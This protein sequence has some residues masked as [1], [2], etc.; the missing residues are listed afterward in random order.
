MSLEREIKESLGRHADDARP[1]PAGLS[2]IER[3]VARAHRRR[4]GLVTGAGVIVLAAIGLALPR[5]L[6][7]N[8]PGLYNPGDDPSVDA[9]ATATP[10]E[11]KVFRNERDA[12]QLSMPKDW[13]VTRFEGTVEL[14]P[15]GQVGRNARGG[16]RAGAE[17]DGF[18]VELQQ[19]V[20]QPYDEPDP[21]Y[22]EAGYDYAPT[23][24]VGGRNA[25][26]A[27]RVEK[28]GSR[29]V[30]V[31]IDWTGA[32]CGKDVLCDAE[33]ATLRISMLATS[34]ELWD[35]FEADGQIALE[36]LST[37]QD[38]PEPAGTV[39]TLYGT[40]DDG[41]PYDDVT[42]FVVRFMDARIEGAGA[43]S[44]LTTET[45]QQY[46]QYEAG[47]PKGVGL[48]SYQCPHCDPPV[49][50]TPWLTY[51]IVRRDA[52][53]ANPFEYKVELVAPI[54]PDPDHVYTSELIGVGR[55]GAGYE[56]RSVRSAGSGSEE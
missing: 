14:L 36:M 31:R 21:D 41:V 19:F 15:P 9:T 52:V 54:G 32:G 3:K 45:S 4:L 29:E 44:F 8:N 48:Y 24:P 27:E 42:Q 20:R 16:W 30:V 5:L 40:V 17:G 33:T 18:S 11:M 49:P 56:I 1:G 55:S 25:V 37:L 35:R 34:A 22:M 43:E 50:A 39:T 46:E 53:D 23:E 10:V 51:R 28:N 13:S 26:R 47:G 38:A 2:A 12:Y 7:D 6:P